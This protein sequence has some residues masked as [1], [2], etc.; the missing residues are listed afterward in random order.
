MKRKYNITELE[1]Q[2]YVGETVQ[3][4]ELR[5]KKRR[6]RLALKGRKRYNLAR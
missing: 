2:T 6:E 4:A 1:R 3:E 5:R